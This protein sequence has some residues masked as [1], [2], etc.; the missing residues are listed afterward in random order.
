MINVTKGKILLESRSDLEFENG[1]VLNPACIEKDGIVH[2]F[3]RAV[4]KRNFSTIGYC[5]LKNNQVIYRSDTPVLIP[6]YLYERMGMED[7]RITFI[8][9]KYYML[10]TAYDGLNALIAY[11]TSND[12][13]TWTKKGLISPQISYDEAEDIFKESGV[14]D[15]YSFFEQYFRYENSDKVHL[16]EKDA[17]LFPKKINGQYALIHRILPG[18]Q[19]CY[20]NDFEQLTQDFWRKYYKDLNSFLI[21]DPKLDYENGYIGGGAVPIETEKGWLLIYHSVNEHKGKKIYRASVSLLDLKNPQKIIS[22]LPY[23]L[24]SPEEI[25]EKKGEV[26]NVVFPSATAIDNDT[27]SIY[28]GAADIRIGVR[29]V[30][31]SKLLKELL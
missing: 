12:L 9:G 16:W 21:L 8:D 13:K 19:I 28:Y 1:G 17:M 23:P 22:R 26:N 31:L 5:Q 15:R 6:E 24:F 7:P 2:M 4:R 14:S 20:F 29:T 11:A 30:S 10:Y 25:W 18:I 27:L 3:Y